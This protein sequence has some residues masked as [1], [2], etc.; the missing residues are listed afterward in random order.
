MRKKVEKEIKIC[1]C[2]GS[3]DCVF[4]ECTSCG[5]HFCYECNKKRHVGKEFAHS[6][7]CSGS[8][9]VYFCIGCLSEPTP[10]TAEILDAYQTVQRLRAENAAWYEDFKARSDKAE[11]EVRKIIEKHKIK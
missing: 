4:N 3:D 5:K 9:D 8:G 7:Y 2:C 1:D 6:V 10:R 11:A